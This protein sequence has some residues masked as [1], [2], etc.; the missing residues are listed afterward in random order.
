MSCSVLN[1]ETYGPTLGLLRQGSER[2]KTVKH[3]KREM[4]EIKL[5]LSNEA[6]EV[7]DAYA[8]T[9]GLSRADAARVALY[10]APQL[11]AKLGQGP[12]PLR[13]VLGP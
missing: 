8:R 12:V 2:M 11:A 5:T 4:A 7:L 13:D 6:L 10:S 9:H 1:L 3:S